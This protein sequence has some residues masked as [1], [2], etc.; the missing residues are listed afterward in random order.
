[1]KLKLQIKDTK[2]LANA[3]VYVIEELIKKKRIKNYIDTLFPPRAKQANYSD[4]DLLLALTYSIISGG[5]FLEDM[6]YIRQH[7]SNAYLEL[8][9]SDTIGYRARQ[10]AVDTERHISQRG[11]EHFFNKNPV[12]NQVLSKLA[13]YLNPEFKQKGQTLDYDNVLIT[14]ERPDSRFS[15]KGTPSY[16]PG[17]LLIDRQPIYIEGRNGNSPPKFLMVDSLRRGFEVSLKN[18]IKIKAIRIDG[19]GYQEA[20]FTFLVEQ[21]PEVKYYIRADK[22]D[23]GFCD[24]WQAASINKVNG[25]VLSIPWSTPGVNG[26]PCRLVAWRKPKKSPQYDLF[27]GN[28][29]YWLILTNDWEKSAVEVIEFYNHRGTAEQSFDIMKNDFNWRHLAF[30]NL[31]DNTVYLILTAMAYLIYRW[32]LRIICRYFPAL[33]PYTRIK[34]FILYFLNVPGKWIRTARSVQLNL[35]TKQPY[36]QILNPG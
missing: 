23:L 18:G 28:Y 8:P 26:S 27:D 24:E 20:V 11:V 15:Y 10:L 30:G 33:T 31:K 13:V 16:H 4:S 25:E 35:Y 1:M 32:I 12:L 19:A 2:I 22:T 17:A 21:Y 14:T 5:T 34:R 6:N 9:S 36:H 3:G 29:E 7:L